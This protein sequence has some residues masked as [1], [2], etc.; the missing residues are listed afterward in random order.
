MSNSVGIDALGFALPRLVL[1]MQAFAEGRGME[2]EKLRFGLGL[3]AMAVPDTDEDCVTLAAQAAWN[4]I[5]QQGIKPHEI[6]RIYLGTE[7]A[8]DAAKPSA[9]Y[10]HGLLE[11]RF[12]AE[13]GPRSLAHCDAL[14]MTF[15][16]AGGV[17][18]L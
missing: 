18:A 11:E 9:T 4:L 8:V 16:C 17:D 14:D 15:A 5:S 7:S 12:A 10:V 13:F 2:Y 6:G 3:E 1:P